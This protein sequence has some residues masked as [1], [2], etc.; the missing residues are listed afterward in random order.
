M[1]IERFYMRLYS[2]TRLLR[3]LTKK[4]EIRL[5]ALQEG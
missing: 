1:I 5:A 2:T 4:A 3:L